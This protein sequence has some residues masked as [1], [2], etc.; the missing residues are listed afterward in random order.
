MFYDSKVAAE[1]SQPYQT[2]EASDGSVFETRPNTAG[3]ITEIEPRKISVLRTQNLIEDWFLK[4]LRENVTNIL[5][6]RMRITAYFTFFK[7]LENK[8]IIQN[9]KYI[10]KVH[11]TR[12][13]RLT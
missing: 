10:N 3:M 8:I 7:V 6:W 1:N 4:R 11:M 5:R 13:L 12:I 2:Y 9:A